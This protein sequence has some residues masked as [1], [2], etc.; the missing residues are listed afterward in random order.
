MEIRDVILVEGLFDL[1][2]ICKPCHV[3]A[4][5]LNNNDV[6]VR[7]RAG[8]LV[9]KDC[10]GCGLSKPLAEFG[11]RV[12][13]TLPTGEKQSRG[14]LKVCRQCISEGRGYLVPNST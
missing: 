1:A 14:R 7:E 4:D 5:A 11:S 9:R 2:S 12:A 8:R 10:E 3:I 13:R 6:K